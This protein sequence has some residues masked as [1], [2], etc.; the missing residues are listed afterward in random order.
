MRQLGGRYHITYRTR[1][2]VHEF[3]CTHCSSQSEVY[4][5]ARC[6]AGVLRSSVYWQALQRT[7]GHERDLSED[8]EADHAARAPADAL[9]RFV[10][11]CVHFTSTAAWEEHIPDSMHGAHALVM[12]QARHDKFVFFEDGVKLFDDLKRVASAPGRAVTEVRPQALSGDA[13]G[14]AARDGDGG[15]TA[16]QGGA[17]CTGVAGDAELVEVVGGHVAGFLQC[18][19]LLPAAVVKALAR[20]EAKTRGAG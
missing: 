18:R 13:A 15:G 20:L 5:R 16:Q 19:R 3:L 6:R 14:A 10:T 7:P 8:E 12:L 1:A 2:R 4:A 11:F 9:H 17:V